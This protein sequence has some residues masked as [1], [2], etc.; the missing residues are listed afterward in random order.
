MSF[1]KSLGVGGVII[2]AALALFATML[3]RVSI[4][5]IVD[6]AGGATRIPAPICKFWLYSFRGTEDDIAEVKDAYGLDLVFDLPDPVEQKRLLAF[7]IERGV[8]I[9]QK[10]GKE[11]FT[12]LHSA[13]LDRNA[14]RIRILREAGA[15]ADIADN[16][17]QMTPLQLAEHLRKNHPH[18]DMQPVIEALTSKA[19]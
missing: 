13:V 8:D 19:P 15:H 3:S 9:N 12:A 2:I 4:A 1:R 7:F 14:P 11:G 10:R 16:Q 6:C 5:S 18:D 17:Y